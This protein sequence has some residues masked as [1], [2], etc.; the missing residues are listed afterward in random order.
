MKKSIPAVLLAAGVLVA[1]GGGGGGATRPTDTVPASAQSDPPVASLDPLGQIPASGN[2]IDFTKATSLTSAEL[3]SAAALNGTLTPAVSLSNAPSIRVAIPELGVDDTFTAADVTSILDEFFLIQTASRS[4]GGTTRTVSY[5]VPDSGDTNGFKLQ[6]SSLG[7]WNTTDIATGAVT[8]A[9][10]FSVGTRTLGS[11]I[12]TTG[13]ANY[14]GFMLGQAF[15]G[16]NQYSV[17]A[18]AAAIADFGARSV[19]YS[20][21]R[22]VKTDLKT[23]EITQAGNYDMS[24]TLRYASGVNALSGTVTT[25]D[26]KTGTAAG[27]FY[28]P[29]AAE[30]G[31]TFKLTSSSGSLVGGA[32]LKR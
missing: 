4:G 2:H 25:A 20:T 16:P 19:S 17:N 22:S 12:P 7:V 27:T 28:G 5:V 24:G 9:V 30:L 23:N 8:Q 21:Q 18:N 26:G 13:T 6:F 14:F 11:D 10:A 3:G 1:C 31:M 29:Q 32:A 15:E